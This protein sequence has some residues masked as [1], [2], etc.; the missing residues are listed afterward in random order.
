MTGY[1]LVNLADVIKIKAEV[2][3]LT[4]EEDKETAENAFESITDAISAF[5]CPQNHDVE[6]FLKQKAIAFAEQGVAATYLVF[7]SH[8]GAP[9]LVGYFTLANKF[10][11]IPDKTIG[12]KALKRRISKF[13]EH[14]EDLKGYQLSMPL[15]AQLGKNFSNEYNT[16]I[17]G[18]ELL[19]IACN[20]IA[21]IQ[22]MISG[23]MTYVEC[24]DKPCLIDFYTSNGFRRI[25]NRTLN[26]SEKTEAD[27][28]YLVQL[29]KYI[30]R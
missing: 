29:I 27:P 6:T 13:G 21:Q 7:A 3:Q 22:I 4:L 9:V 25:A 24:E 2:T 12:T 26:K 20:T 5:S 11:F 14:N 23:K 1:N 30:K 15:I 10:L 16:L 8:K 18:D 19:K 28:E 17:S